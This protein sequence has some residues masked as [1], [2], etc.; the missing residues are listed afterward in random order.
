MRTHTIETLTVHH[1]GEQW[2]YTGPARY[3]VWQDLHTGRGWGDVAYHYIIGIDGTVYEARDTA[4]A[5]D[6][7]TNYDPAGHFLVVVEGNFDK[8]QPTQAQ[9]D[10]LVRVLAWASLLFGVLPS[11]IGGHRD[12]AATAC[13]GGNLYPYIATG[14]L[15]RD[16]EELI[17][18]GA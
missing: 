12:H 1:A 13:P 2:G 8:E 4:Y 18:E 16:V 17:A 7:N 14:D 6:T 15:Q 3:R 5:G 10:S 9:L 11:T